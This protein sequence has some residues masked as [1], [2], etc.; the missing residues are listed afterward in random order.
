MEQEIINTL[1]KDAKFSAAIVAAITTIFTF[2]ITLLTKNYIENRLLKSKLKTE[3]DFE[4]RKEIKRILAKNKVHLLNACENLNHRLWNFATNHDKGWLDINGKFNDTHYYYFHSFIYRFLVVLAW[5]KKIEQEI[6]WLDTTISSKDDLYLI[7]FLKIFPQI[8]CDLSFSTQENP[9]GDYA[10]DHFFR[11]DFNELPNAVIKEDEV[12]SYSDFISNT[13]K[14]DSLNKIYQYFDGL[15]PDEDRERWDR[16]N[17][18]NLL[19]II[20]LNSYGYD[21]QKTDEKKM[22]IAI[23]NPRRSRKLNGFKRT[24][25]DYKLI[26]HKEVKNFVKLIK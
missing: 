1:L 17:L 13:D 12:I 11:N 9:N 10:V 5:I 16:L 6:V 8:F 20:F 26:S 24:F 2:F 7:K 22:K 3:H 25:E 18:L 15:N 23:S 14:Y 19:L 4:Q 21:F